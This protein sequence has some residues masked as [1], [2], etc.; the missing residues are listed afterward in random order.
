MKR[1]NFTLI[2]LLIV[3]AIIAILAALLLPALNKARDRA[4]AILCTNN[5]KQNVLN[6][7]LYAN[8]F[9]G[10]YV[11][12]F[13]CGSQEYTWSRMLQECGYVKVNSPVLYCPSQKQDNSYYHNY[14]A[15]LDIPASLKFS[16][17]WGIRSKKIR[18]AAAF[19]Y[20][21]DS[22]NIGKM[23]QSSYSGIYSSESSTLMTELR[24]SHQANSGYIDGHVASIG[25][26]GLKDFARSINS[27][28][29]GSYRD[30]LWAVQAYYK[31]TRVI[32]GV[33]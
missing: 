17:M 31:G 28:Y 33:Y 18:N 25:F 3:I 23:L 21:M 5:L 22:I 9:D 6:M 32:Q 2:E 30:K 29:G 7:N 4:K 15:I 11:C 24:H 19:I 10:D 20:L 13:V 8:D 1:K 14:G 16:S 12:Y 27:D 26:Q